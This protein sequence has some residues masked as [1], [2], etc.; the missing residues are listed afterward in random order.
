M[1]PTLDVS[2]ITPV[3]LLYELFYAIFLCSLKFLIDTR[4]PLEWGLAN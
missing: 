3:F 4:I 2:Y 1:S